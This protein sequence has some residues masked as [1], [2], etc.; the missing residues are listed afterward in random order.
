MKANGGTAGCGCGSPS[1]HH[2]RGG[3]ACGCDEGCKLGSYVR[4]LFFAGQL[5]T[6]EDLDLLGEYVTSKNRLHNRSFIGDGVVCGLEVLCHPCSEGK[7]VVRPGH[8]LDCCGN[9]IVVACEAELDV[10]AMVHR[11]RVEKLGGWDCGDPCEQPKASDA[12]ANRNGNAAS[13]DKDGAEVLP[14]ARRYALYV[15]YCEEVA[16]PVAPYATDEPC[17]DEG[18]QPSR[19]REGYRFELRC[20]EEVP[21]PDDLSARVRACREAVRNI[22]GVSRPGAVWNVLGDRIPSALEQH[23]QAAVSFTAEDAAVLKKAIPSLREFVD[24]KAEEPDAETVRRRLEDLRSVVMASARLNALEEEDRRVALERFEELR[25][26]AD[27]AQEAARLAAEAIQPHL[28][29]AVEDDVERAMA[30]A[31][32]AE[33]PQFTKRDAVTQARDDMRLFMAMEGAPVDRPM[34]ISVERSLVELKRRLLAA[35]DKAWL[36]DCSL[37]REVERIEVSEPSEGDVQRERLAR[38]SDASRKLSAAILRYGYGCICAS[39]LPP[40]RPCDDMGVLLATLE[41]QECEVTHICNLERRVPL[42]A[43]ALR[44]WLPI[45]DVARMLEESCCE[46]PRRWT[47][48]GQPVERRPMGEL[49]EAP[50]AVRVERTEPMFMRTEE[51]P[52][53]IPT[54]T[55]MLDLA[56]LRSEQAERIAEMLDGLSGLRDLVPAPAVTP[57]E[58]EETSAEHEK[59]VADLAATAAA[60]AVERVADRRLE[61]LEARLADLTAVKREVAALR[62]RSDDL[63][64]RNS[65]LEKRNRA[66]ER[67]VARL[68]EGG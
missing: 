12:A 28:E 10:N 35:L 24:E 11:L 63:K 26:A 37:R 5:L 30:R 45:H 18:C 48:P 13:D 23:S 19:V 66:L 53:D 49:V 14:A 22:R 44:H 40:C 62:R 36:T 29:R 15:Y 7:V 17:G 51:P 65:D 68:A 33:G 46:T 61:K 8:A 4:P 55:R 67:Q 2:T 52:Q 38:A 20:V 64:R 31:L 1:G 47:K 41:V 57:P 9:D 32:V 34:I 43:T 3:C 21:E 58:L 6:E 25:T 56:G 59:E 27:E 50:T 39:T 54:V 42:T 60:E 16:D